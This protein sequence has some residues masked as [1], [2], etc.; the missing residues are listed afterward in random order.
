MN[1]RKI[2]VMVYGTFD[3]LHPGHL[4]FLRQAKRLGDFL[5]VSVSR[6][7][8]AKK[9]KGYYPVFGEKERLAIV[10]SLKYVDQAVLG[11]RSHYL[12]HTLKLKPDIV[13]LGYDQ[14]AYERHLRADIKSGKLKARLVRLAPYQS[15]KYKS[16]RYKKLIR[17]G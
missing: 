4:N 15:G 2:R 3:I 10:S 8:N 17:Q 16:T 7:V 12:A 9:F 6:D 5:I 11:G 1:K 14:R 13:A